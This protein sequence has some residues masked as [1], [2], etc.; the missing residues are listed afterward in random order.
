MPC[1]L[2]A[3]EVRVDVGMG[4]DM[5]EEF[6]LLL[7]KKGGPFVLYFSDSHMLHLKSHVADVHLDAKYQLAFKNSAFVAV[8]GSTW[9]QILKNINGEELTQYQA[10]LGA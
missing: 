8:G 6:L 3:A 9:K 10:Y 1:E 5:L 7:K 2:L 4:T